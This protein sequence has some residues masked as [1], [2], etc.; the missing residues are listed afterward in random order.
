[1]YWI[2]VMVC[3]P[4]SCIW[5]IYCVLFDLYNYSHVY[6]CI[7]L[8][9]RQCLSDL[10]VIRWTYLKNLETKSIN[11]TV[12]GLEYLLSTMV[13]VPSNITM[14]RLLLWRLKQYIIH[15]LPKVKKKVGRV[16]KRA[17]A[18]G[19]GPGKGYT[20]IGV[21]QGGCKGKFCMDLIHVSFAVK[22]AAEYKYW[23]TFSIDGKSYNFKIAFTMSGRYTTNVSVVSF[24]TFYL[25][26]MYHI[27][28]FFLKYPASIVLTL[29]L[30]SVV[31]ES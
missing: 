8:Y 9:L 10:D 17:T 6:A 13:K 20:S 28:V 3:P 23:T 27:P 30:M 19:R 1:M 2:I 15:K 26:K 29:I 31:A 16:S 4:L 24:Y 25:S 18:S 21:G 14:G 22:P 11:N 12:S 5:N 7:T